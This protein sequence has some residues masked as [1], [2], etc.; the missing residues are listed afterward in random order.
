MKLLNSELPLLT[1]LFPDMMDLTKF[2]KK[3]HSDRDLELTDSSKTRTMMSIQRKRVAQEGLEGSKS[4]PGA[5]IG[6][7]DGK[8]DKVNKKKVEEKAPGEEFELRSYTRGDNS[9]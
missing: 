6:P 9:I 3:G 7:D 4:S 8:F 2:S 1:S 5:N